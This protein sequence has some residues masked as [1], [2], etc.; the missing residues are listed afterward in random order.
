[1]RKYI[2]KI[3]N[4]AERK[5]Y[6]RK[7]SIRKKISG[8][9]EVPRICVHKTNKHVQVQVI[10]DD[11]Q[12]TILTCQT[13]GKNA[14]VAGAKKNKDG[15]KSVGAKVAEGLKGQGISKAVL[16]RNG[17]TYTGLI[18]VLTDSIRESG[19]SI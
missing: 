12:K 14:G 15:I 7:L 13:Y 18:V 3:R 5:K 11:A 4:E 1:M 6:R 8:T 16:D 9:A 17:N 10:D 19:I 2:G